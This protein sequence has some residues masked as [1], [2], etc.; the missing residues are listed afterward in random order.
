MASKRSR[1]P[2]VVQFHDVVEDEVAFVE[3]IVRSR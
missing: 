1:G 2:A 3:R